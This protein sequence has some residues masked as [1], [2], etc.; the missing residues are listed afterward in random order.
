MIVVTSITLGIPL[1]TADGK[2]IAYPD[3][4]TLD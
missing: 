2:I 1:L 4:V 3:V